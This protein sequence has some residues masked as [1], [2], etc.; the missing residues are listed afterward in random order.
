[1]RVTAHL[2]H[3]DPEANVDTFGTVQPGHQFPDLLA[4]DRGQRCRLRLYQHHVHAQAAQAGRHLAADE[5]GADDHGA[6]RRGRVLAQRHAL[7]E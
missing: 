4:E 7:V 5:A 3:P 1:M 2:R 6:L